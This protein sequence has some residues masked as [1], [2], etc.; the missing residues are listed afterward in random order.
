MATRHIRELFN[1][2]NQTTGE[3]VTVVATATYGPSQV[4]RA[5]T[6]VGHIVKSTSLNLLTGE[7]LDL[8]GR[9]ITVA[10]TKIQILVSDEDHKTILSIGQGT[11]Q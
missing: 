1:A 9:T 5:R 10:C 4:P 8:H 2:T 7:K 3:E 6:K 11:F